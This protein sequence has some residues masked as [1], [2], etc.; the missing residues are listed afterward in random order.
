MCQKPLNR[1][2]VKKHGEE[3]ELMENRPRARELEKG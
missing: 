3:K 2:I 1:V